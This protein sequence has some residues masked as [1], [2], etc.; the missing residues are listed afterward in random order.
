[1][2]YLPI[3]RY[4]FPEVLPSP[5]STTYQQLL[6]QGPQGAFKI[7]VI[8]LYLPKSPRRMYIPILSVRTQQ[9]LFYPNI[10]LVKIY[11]SQTECLTLNQ[12]SH[13]QH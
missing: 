4:H 9:W 12:A 6:I 5:D 13:P 10:W 3:T 8:P 1:M 7:Q 11:S 2:A